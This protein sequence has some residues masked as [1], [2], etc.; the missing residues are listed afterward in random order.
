LHRV[1]GVKTRYVQRGGGGPAA[2]TLEGPIA[3]AP[4]LIQGLQLGD[5]CAGDHVVVHTASAVYDLTVV[6]PRDR[7]VVICGG[8]FPTATSARVEGCSRDG[9]FLRPGS[10][11]VGCAMELTTSTGLVVTGP[12]TAIGFVGRM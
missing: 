4:A 2:G 7:E 9:A 6:S 10:L 3:A 8:S 12:V 11:A 1:Y 5:L